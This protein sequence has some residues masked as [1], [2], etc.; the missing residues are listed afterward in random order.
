MIFKTQWNANDCHGDIVDTSTGEV[1]RLLKEGQPMPLFPRKYETTDKP[2]LTVPDQ[3]L[4][5][6]QILDRYARGLPLGGQKVPIYDGDDYDDMPDLTMM[7]EPDRIQYMMD[8]RDELNELKE[9]I[10]YDKKVEADAKAQSRTKSQRTSAQELEIEP[11]DA[12][13][14]GGAPNILK[15]PGV[16]GQS[17]ATKQKG[18]TE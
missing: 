3:A 10:A 7:D 18:G 1:T 12:Q 13:P 9:K 11:D 5:I 15:K 6:K 14:A 4:T 17:P 2:S 16:Q 8:M